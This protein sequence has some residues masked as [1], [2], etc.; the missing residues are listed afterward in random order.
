MPQAEEEE[1]KAIQDA[2]VAEYT[3]DA[4][5]SLVVSH[6]TTYLNEWMLDSGCTYHVS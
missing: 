3:S 1:E 2:N 4:K 5:L 6:S